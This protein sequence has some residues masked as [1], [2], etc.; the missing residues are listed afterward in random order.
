MEDQIILTS[1]L[2]T[3]IIIAFIGCTGLWTF[4]GKLFDA[5]LDKRKRKR[6]KNDSDADQ[7]ASIAKLRVVADE[8]TSQLSVITEAVMLLIYDRFEHLAE[9]YLAAGKISMKQGKILTAFYKVY[10]ALGGNGWADELLE[11]VKKL[12]DG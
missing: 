2:I 5:W 8:H 6:Q 9:K 12:P 1:D 10:K 4:L 11:R 7:T 3:K